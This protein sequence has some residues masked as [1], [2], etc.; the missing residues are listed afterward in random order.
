MDDELSLDSVIDI[1]N[2]F[3]DNTIDN[4]EESKK[5]DTKDIKEET[6]KEEKEE[7]VDVENLFASGNNVEET[8]DK[9]IEDTPYKFFFYFQH[10]LF[11][12]S[13]SC[14]GGCFF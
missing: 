7:Q 6:K 2:L 11:H 4:P 5:E 14:G 1:D 8:E 3:V 10:F 9:K 12:Y 13:G